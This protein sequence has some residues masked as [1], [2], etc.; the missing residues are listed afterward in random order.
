[1]EFLRI[2]GIAMLI[3]GGANLVAATPPNVSTAED[4]AL[5]V[6]GNVLLILAVSMIVS[7]TKGRK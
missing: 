4:W 2:I 5:W 3:G 7:M 1:M 6:L